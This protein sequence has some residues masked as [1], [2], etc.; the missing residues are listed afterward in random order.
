MTKTCPQGAITQAARILRQ[1]GVVAFPTET[2]YGLG[3]DPFN[4]TALERLFAVKQR[5]SKKA[6]LLLIEKKAQVDVFARHIPHDFISLMARFWPGPLTLVFPALPRVSS[7]VTGGTG[8]VGIRQ[9]PHFL[10]QQIVQMYGGPVTGT[11]ANISGHPP[12][13]T[14]DQVA[15]IF[16]SDVD[17]IVDGGITPGGNGSTVVGFRQ[18]IFCIREG[19]IPFSHIKSCLN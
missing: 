8:T 3:V 2:Y 7:L 17:Y 1:G 13:T 6:I 15:E 10:V 9:S 14:A 16:G 18:T 4:T 12:A 5:S 19:L 11:S